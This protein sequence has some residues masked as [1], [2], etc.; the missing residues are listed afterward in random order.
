[1]TGNAK[2]H[3]MRA[4][5]K[6]HKTVIIA[7]GVPLAVPLLVWQIVYKIAEAEKFD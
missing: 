3:G 4:A 2:R 5:V 6:R 7:V 1:M